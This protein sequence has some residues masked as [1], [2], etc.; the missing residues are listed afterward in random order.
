M[1]SLNFFPPFLT[2]PQEYGRFNPGY[3][4]STLNASLS[5]W[6]HKRKEYKV[7]IQGVGLLSFSS[8][9]IYHCRNAE[10]PG[11]HDMFYSDLF[12]SAGGGGVW[13]VLPSRSIPWILQF[14]ILRSSG[15]KK[16]IRA[17]C[18]TGKEV[19]NM[20]A[21]RLDSNFIPHEWLIFLSYYLLV[22]RC[23]IE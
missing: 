3:M 19:Y 14:R 10:K 11:K 20:K 13:D 5:V 18:V 4:G 12:V 7:R 23:S 1:L 8:C 21:T 22:T 15:N 16:R 9:G 2:L 17:F 6:H